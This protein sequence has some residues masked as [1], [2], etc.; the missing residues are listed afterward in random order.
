MVANL[1]GEKAPSLV[2]VT[3]ILT[4]RQSKHTTLLARSIRVYRRLHASVHV[5]H[6]EAGSALGVSTASSIQLIFAV[7]F[8]RA[9]ALEWRF[10]L[11]AEGA[12]SICL[13]VSKDCS[14]C[15]HMNRAAEMAH[16]LHL[17]GAIARQAGLI[18][19][20]RHFVRIGVSARRRDHF[21]LP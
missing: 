12:A 10:V 8:T 17:A 21:C 1:N 4:E 3:Y 5:A 19:H 13:L 9:F 18:L 2:Y 7:A 6:V 16:M 14:S 20:G 15:S 11:Q